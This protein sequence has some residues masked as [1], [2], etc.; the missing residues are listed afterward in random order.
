ME[1]LDR[2]YIVHCRYIDAESIGMG[3]AAAYR[4]CFSVLFYDSIAFYW[5]WPQIIAWEING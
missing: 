1:G 5:S 2:P 4:L 3:E